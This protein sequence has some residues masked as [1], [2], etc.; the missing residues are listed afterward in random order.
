MDFSTGGGSVSPPV[1]PAPPAPAP[2][3][4]PPAPPQSGDPTQLLGWT[5]ANQNEINIPKKAS[6][7]KSCMTCKQMKLKCDQ[8]RPTCGRCS[9]RGSVCTW[10]NEK[11]EREPGAFE[12]AMSLLRT[13]HSGLEGKNLLIR[14]SKNL[15]PRSPCLHPLR[16]P[17]LQQPIPHL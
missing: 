17:N 16:P 9:N 4:A 6:K 12:Y 3:T 7:Q 10:L 8:V 15:L 1:P 11:L 14:N 13:L 2:V 5:D